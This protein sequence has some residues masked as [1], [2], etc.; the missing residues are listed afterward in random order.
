MFHSLDEIYLYVYKDHELLTIFSHEYQ[1]ILHIV[2][3]KYI[4]NREEIILK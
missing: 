1:L 2:P 4:L 3:P